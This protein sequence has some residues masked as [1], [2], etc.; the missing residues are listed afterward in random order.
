M[1]T[2]WEDVKDVISNMITKVSLEVS[3]VRYSLP[4]WFNI[5]MPVERAMPE[6]GI[7][8]EELDGY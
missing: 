7:L 6:L 4:L 3:D 5:F 8:K 2:D 1:Y